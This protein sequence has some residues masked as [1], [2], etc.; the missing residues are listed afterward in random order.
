M[1]TEIT[2]HN[3]ATIDKDMLS[4]PDTNISQNVSMVRE[5]FSHCFAVIFIL[6]DRLIYRQV[7]TG[8]SS[9]MIG[10]Y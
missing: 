7:R 2:S 6:Y 8:Q 9:V 1:E 10:I 4:M 5:V 3:L